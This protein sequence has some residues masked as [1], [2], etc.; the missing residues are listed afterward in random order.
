MLLAKFEQQIIK[1]ELKIL[2]TKTVDMA[3][4]VERWIRN[5]VNVICACKIITY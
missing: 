4:K 3:G 2:I 5:P 1:S